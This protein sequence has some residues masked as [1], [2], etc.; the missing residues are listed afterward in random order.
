MRPLQR[1]TPNLPSKAYKTFQVKAPKSTHTRPASCEEVECEQYAKGWRMKIDL[2]TDLGQKQ[3][4]YI[5]K[6]AGR[7][8]KVA[9]QR[10]GMV[11]LEFPGGQPCFQE[12]RVRNELPEKFLVKGGD[13]RGNPLG[14]K[15]R[16]HT[17]P[18]HWV[19]EFAENQ[20][21]LKTAIERG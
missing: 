18:E 7:A 1:I 5:K 12:H 14:T 19:E 8:Y 6:H 9:D 17:K 20:D 13:Y 11:T 21:R 2:N 4:Y 16:V 3:A 15:T 10:D